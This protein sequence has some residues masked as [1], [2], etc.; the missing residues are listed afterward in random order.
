[1]TEILSFDVPRTICDIADLINKINQLKKVSHALDTECQPQYKYSRPL[2]DDVKV[3]L[4]PK[5]RK[6]RT[7]SFSLL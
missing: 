2:T 4:T 3:A 5:R 7:P 1:M 6:T